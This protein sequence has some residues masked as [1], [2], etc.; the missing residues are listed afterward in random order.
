MDRLARR[1]LWRGPARDG[2]VR[3][4]RQCILA[5]RPTGVAQAADFELVDAPPAPLGEGQIRV[6]NSFLSV[7]PAMRGWIAAKG[8][9]SEPVDNGPVMRPRA[10]GRA[11]ETGKWGLFQGGRIHG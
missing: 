5:S 1:R 8:N 10:P 2:T 6:R 3:M 4:N 11:T 9:S 7:E